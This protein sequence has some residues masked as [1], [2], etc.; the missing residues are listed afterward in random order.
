MISVHLYVHIQRQN[1][2]LVLRSLSSFLLILIFSVFY[3]VQPLKVTGPPQQSDRERGSGGWVGGVCS[4]YVVF[5]F[6]L[7][8]P[9]PVIITPPDVSTSSVLPVRLSLSLSRSVCLFFFC[10]FYSPKRRTRTLVYYTHTTT[11]QLTTQKTHASCFCGLVIIVLLSSCTYTH[12]NATF[13]FFVCV[14]CS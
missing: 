12:T 4:C 11:Q 9:S 1:T 2:R 3:F 6:P 10:V 7:V 5:S 8:S 14:A 13:F